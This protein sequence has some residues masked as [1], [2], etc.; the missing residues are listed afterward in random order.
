MTQNYTLIFNPI[1]LIC[2][3]QISVAVRQVLTWQ[4]L[5]VAVQGYKLTYLEKLTYVSELKMENS[6]TLLYA[7]TTR[8]ITISLYDQQAIAKIFSIGYRVTA[9]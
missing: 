9:W 3:L 4:V 2:Y 7:V 6:F 8:Y 5:A 1:K